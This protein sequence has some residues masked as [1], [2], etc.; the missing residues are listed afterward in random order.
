MSGN[1]GIGDAEKSESAR[2]PALTKRRWI[3]PEM[4]TLYKELLRIRDNPICRK[5]RISESEKELQIDHINGDPNDWRLENLQ[6]LCGPCNTKAYHE[7]ERELL[8]LEH[9]TVV[10]V[11][12]RENSQG[13]EEMVERRVDFGLASSSAELKVNRE[14]EPWYRREVIWKVGH[15]KFLS[16]DAALHE[17]SEICGMSPVTARRYLKKLTSAAGPLVIEETQTGGKLLRL[18]PEYW[19]LEKTQA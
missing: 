4:R 16:V 12:E 14:K 2:K 8:L 11:N 1:S 7:R 10:S 19:K 18:R 6:L 15:D 13:V 17:F 3:S 5:C 9:E